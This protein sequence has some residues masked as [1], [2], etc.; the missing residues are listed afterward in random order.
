VILPVAE[1]S[2]SCLGAGHCPY[3]Q[4]KIRGHPPLQERD[5]EYARVAPRFGPRSI[6]ERV[7]SE[8]DRF[9]CVR[10]PHRRRSRRLSSHRTF[11]RFRGDVLLTRSPP[12]SVPAEEVFHTAIAMA[13]GQGPRGYALLASLSLAKLYQSTGRPD[14]ARAI[15]APALGGLLP[16]PEM[17][18]IA[19]ARALL[20]LSLTPQR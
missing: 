1:R 4:S 6:R 7:S 12:A 17:P 13:N 20:G 8:Q 16:T 18:E 14:H 15:L 9:R 2:A 5:H 10:R 3:F 11:T 19:E